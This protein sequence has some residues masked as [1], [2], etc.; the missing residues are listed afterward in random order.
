VVLIPHLEIPLDPDAPEARRWVVEELSKPE[1]ASAQP[2]PFDLAMQAIRDWIASLFEGA[3]GVP[4]PLLAVLAVIVVA[5]LLV[6]AL[7]VYG[8]PRLRRRRRAVAP[9]FD[10]HDLRDLR[11]LRRAAE[12]A[13]GSEDWALAIEER[14]R[15]IVRGVVDRDLVQVHPGTTAHGFADAA[16]RPLPAHAEALRAAA[17]DFDAVRYLGRAG[18]RERYEAIVRL[19]LAVEATVPEH[20]E[21]AVA[22]A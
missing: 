11:T 13:A 2:T 14:F 21:T 5:V 6:V 16:G 9:L 19:D 1:Y 7:L 4:G 20:A 17:A 8:L 15:A 18:S 22:P 3:T 12:A 10:D